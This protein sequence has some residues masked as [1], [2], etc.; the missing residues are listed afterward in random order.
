MPIHG[1][2][3]KKALMTEGIPTGGSMKPD[4]PFRKAIN[5]IDCLSARR[6]T[7]I[8]YARRSSRVPS[9][10]ADAGRVPRSGTG[11]SARTQRKAAADPGGYPVLRQHRGAAAVRA[12]RPLERGLSVP[13]RG[14]LRWSEPGAAGAR[15]LLWI[16]VSDGRLVRSAERALQ[17]LSARQRGTAAPPV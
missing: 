16:R 2:L 3:N 6:R 15:Q 5:A 8:R 14:S 11:L 13:A 17:R 10:A 1:I 9:R 4:S 12:L 7:F